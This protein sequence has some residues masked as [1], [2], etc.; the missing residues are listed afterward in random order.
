[1][2]DWVHG[3]RSAAP[4]KETRVSLEAEPMYESERLRIIYQ[5]IT[6]PESEGGAG[7]TPKEGEWKNVES[8]FPLHDHQ[9]NN[10]WLKKWSKQWMLLPEDIDE[11]RERLGEKVWSP[12]VFKAACASS[13]V[14]RLLSI[15]PS[16][17][18]TL[19]S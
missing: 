9:Y 8:L 13:N 10:E 4:E 11:I 14:C 15:S 1:M 12:I 17:S 18:L 7:I 5:L 19:P 6:N 2:R 16:P 3:V